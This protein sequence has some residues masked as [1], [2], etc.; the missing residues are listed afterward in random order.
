M[1]NK[2]N[3]KKIKNEVARKFFDQLKELYEDSP[4]KEQ[5]ILVPIYKNLLR[6][7]PNSKRLALNLKNINLG[8][9]NCIRIMKV[10]A[11]LD[12]ISNLSFNKTQITKNTTT[13][14]ANLLKNVTNL[15]KIDLRLDGLRKICTELEEN[16]SLEGLYL[17]NCNIQNEGAIILS[18]MLE[19]NTTLEVLEL[20]KNE[21][22]S[23]GLGFITESLKNNYSLVSFEI[24]QS[25]QGDEKEIE[26]IH[27]YVERNSTIQ[28]VL[29]QILSN[30][31]KRQ[32]KRKLNQF[33]KSVRGMEMLKGKNEQI[34]KTKKGTKLHELFE[35]S[36]KRSKIDNIHD[37]K[38]E[39]GIWRVGYAEMMGR[40]DTQEDVLSIKID[41]LKNTEIDSF[42]TDHSG[43]IESKNFKNYATKSN[44]EVP[45]EEFVQVPIKPNELRNFQVENANFFGLFDGHGGREASEHVAK[46]LPNM[47][48]EKILNGEILEKA[49]RQSFIE[50]HEQMLPWCLYS[51][52]TAV[53]II[54]I[55]KFVWV[56]NLGDSQAVLCRNGYTV[57]LTRPQK[58][59]DPEEKKRIEEAGGFV[60]DGRVNGILAVSRAFGD[61]YLG[62]AISSEPQINSF[63][64]SSSD[65]FIVMACDGVW[66]VL[67]EDA[68][69]AIVGEEIDPQKAAKRV[70]DESYNQGSTDNISVLT[71]F[72]Q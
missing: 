26:E 1:G 16:Q 14:I 9:R 62:K 67:K 47:I 13:Q 11:Q 63:Q 35:E 59:N 42:W 64:L 3:S 71:L 30:T 7:P 37:K 38:I 20:C 2:L 43:Y 68:T 39:N 22:T 21:I 34:N 17:N 40:R 32:F 45:E 15:Q 19:T 65:S 31:C 29:D 5:K 55:G 58:P 57:R 24:D 33:S 10:V 53:V 44:Y 49:I 60:K 8:D 12:Q 6:F 72:I 69:V 27:S 46:I 41:W 56:V 28:E 51:G 36:N 23:R 61:G 18:D 4:Q 48:K 54:T 70:R 66:D 25:N 50:I 52:T